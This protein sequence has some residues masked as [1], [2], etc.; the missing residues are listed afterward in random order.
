MTNKTPITVAYGDGI[1]PEIMS[2]CLKIMLAAGAQLEI[3]PIE[4]G[5]QV[6]LRGNTSGIE[7]SAWESLR[8]TRVF[9]KSPITTPLGGKGLK[10]LNVTIRKA[11]GYM[12]TCV[13]ACPTRRPSRLSTP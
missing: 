5:E 11:L 2:A 1:G 7:A 8:R 6:Y 12:P 10:S 4:I 13:P 3:E 9:F